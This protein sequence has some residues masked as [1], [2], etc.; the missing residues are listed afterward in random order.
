MTKK[1]ST[2]FAARLSPETTARIEA[3]LDELDQSRSEFV[4]TA[5]EY[6]IEKN[7][8]EIEALYEEG[9]FGAFLVE[10]GV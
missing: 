3:A 7:P 8:D 10:M 2:A 1:S 9:S 6:Y 4:R 5:I